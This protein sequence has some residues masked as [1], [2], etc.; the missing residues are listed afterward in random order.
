[1][2]N[3]IKALICVATPPVFT[4]FICACLRWHVF[5]FCVLVGL[6]WT[7]GAVFTMIVIDSDHAD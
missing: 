5:G 7:L 6:V 3:C 4:G 2:N 1:M